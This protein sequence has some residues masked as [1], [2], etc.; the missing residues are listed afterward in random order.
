ME[1]LGQ[2]LNVNP[3]ML[4]LGGGNPA[5]IPDF[6]EIIAEHLQSIAK[7]P[8]ELHR[9]LG[10][11]Q[12]PQGSE[13]FIEALVAFFRGRG[14]PVSKAN[15]CLTHGSQSAFFML[16]N[17]LAGPDADGQAGK[18]CFPMLP[19]YLGYA[20]QGIADA[21]F[22]GCLPIIEELPDNQFKYRVDFDALSRV[23]DCAALCVS[24]PTNPTANVLTD[25]E[26][27]RLGVIADERRIPL[28]VDCAYG[29]PF[30]GVVYQEAET[31][32]TDNRIFVL[33]LSKL[34]LPGVRTGIV[35]ADPDVIQGLVRVNTIVSLANGNF[36][37]ALMTSILKQG[38]LEDVCQNI[39]HPFYVRQ[40]D[41]AFALIKL[42]FVGLDYR[43]HKAEGAFFLWLW[44]PTLPISSAELYT[45]LKARN[46]LVMDGAHFFFDKAAT[47]QHSLQCIRLTYC[48][49]PEVLA[50]AIEIIADELRGLS[51]VC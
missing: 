27:H 41:I 29:D 40:R 37:P 34:G 10:V 19:E 46:V 30:P 31:I 7:D 51:V 14:W 48:A 3:D 21:M 35:V 43:V 32:W 50:R 47:W 12:S 6:E 18:I 1:D 39:L 13:V 16:I 49:K 8:E 44:F 5:H 45:R 2:A 36:G 22:C 28:I 24:R 9:L 11:Y 23:E 33:S 17:L 25:E 42:H 26:V 20:D 15:I 4:F 38:Q